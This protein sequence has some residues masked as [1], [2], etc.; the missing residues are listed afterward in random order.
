ME[1]KAFIILG[2]TSAL[3]SQHGALRANDAI[4]R[5]QCPQP[6]TGVGKIG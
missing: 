1:E 2:M 5:A 3:S 4:S 6:S